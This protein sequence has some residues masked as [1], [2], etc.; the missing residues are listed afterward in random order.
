M[1]SRLISLL[2]RI[3]AVG[4]AL[5]RLRPAH[6][7]GEIEVA[8]AAVDPAPGN[9]VETVPTPDREIAKGPLRDVT[10]HVTASADAVDAPDT[11]SPVV[12]EQPSSATVEIAA[13]DVGAPAPDVEATPITRAQVSMAT[14]TIESV[15][16]D[17]SVDSSDDRPVAIEVEVAEILEE[18]AQPVAATSAP[19]EVTATAPVEDPAPVP[20]DEVSPVSAE[21][22]RPD[23]PDVAMV[24]PE[25]VATAADEL[26]SDSEVDHEIVREP[27]AA[28]AVAA[29]TPE[30]RSQRT[31]RRKTEQPADRAALIRQRWAE[32][33]IRMWNPRSH[34]AGNAT[35][36]IQGRIQ[37]LPPADGE[38]MPRYDKL[39][40]RLLGGQ[41]VCEGVIVEAPVPSGARSISQFAEPRQAER[42]REPARARQV[43]LA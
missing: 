10:L 24:L 30:S 37:L 20:C 15:P 3:P 33:G 13:G 2:R 7:L 38:T 26:R 42:T 28:P 25:A 40:F 21:L 43:A 14:D 22:A 16:A 4:W 5:D 19:V 23:E 31:P 12:A 27:A 34:G 36:A 6:D 11:T 8:R 35:L 1:L 18:P 17:I 32:T 29:L 9:G 39:E 41:I